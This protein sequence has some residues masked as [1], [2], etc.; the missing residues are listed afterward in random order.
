MFQDYLADSI[1][2]GLKDLEYDVIEY[3]RNQFIYR[4]DFSKT[5]NLNVYGRGFTLYNILEL[6]LCKSLDKLPE[7][8][9]CFDF[10]IFGSISNQYDLFLEIKNKVDKKKIVIL[11][12]DD[13][14]ALVPYYGKFWRKKI[15]NSSIHSKYKY[16]KRE[17]TDNTQFYRFY[18]ILPRVITNK[19]PINKNILKINFSI[20]KNK[21][22]SFDCIKNKLFPSHIVDEFVAKNVKGSSTDYAFSNES[23]Y[24]KDLQNS[25]YGITTKRAGWDCLR[26]YEIAANGAV[27]CFKNLNIKPKYCAPHGLVDGLNCISYSD[28]TDLMTRI[29]SISDTEY[30]MMRSHSLEWVRKNTCNLLA[31][32]LLEKCK[33]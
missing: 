27:I 14:A 18:K 12:G 5:N 22:I 20:P 32:Y 28:Y 13:T 10:V 16:F 9:D 30:V 3:P 11:D 15:F 2:V 23:E 24:Y 25:K 31:K 6:D 7:S 17:I 19:I 4:N 1:L 21:I 8:Y 33:S 29:N 26:H